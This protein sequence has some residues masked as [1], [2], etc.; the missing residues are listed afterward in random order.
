MRFMRGTPH[1]TNNSAQHWAAWM[2][3]TI[4]VTI[5]AYLIGSGIPV[6]NNLISLI[7][8]LLATLMAFQ[9]MGLMWIYD[10]AKVRK[11]LRTWKWRATYAW[12]IIVVVL[13]SFIMIGESTASRRVGPC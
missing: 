12:A 11:E 8:S 3:S 7:G 6:F 2:G 10:N 1:L 13:G 5:I 4:T 9:P